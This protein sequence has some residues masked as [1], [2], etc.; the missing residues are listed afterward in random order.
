MMEFNW[1]LD[2][3]Q[4]MKISAIFLEVFFFNF[5]K[6]GTVFCIKSCKMP[7]RQIWNDGFMEEASHL[8][9]AYAKSL[10]E[11]FC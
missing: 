1:L 8:H 2:P 6:T 3:A 11:A 5:I 7:S 10:G 4:C 9:W